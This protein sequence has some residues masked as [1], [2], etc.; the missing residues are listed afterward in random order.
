[1][2]ICIK[3]GFNQATVSF[4]DVKEKAKWT[5]LLDDDKR[6][7]EAEH[8]AYGCITMCLPED[9]LHTFE[10]ESY[11]TS[12]EHWDALA[13]RYKG[14]DVVKKGKQELL[15][16][17]H[18]VFKAM[19]NET[20]DELVNRDYHLMTEMRNHTVTLTNAEKNEKFLYALPSQWDFY[21]VLIKR[22]PT[23]AQMTL[24]TMIAHLRGF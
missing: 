15:K 5:A 14:D 20:L 1:M 16:A 23:Y 19:K 24:D 9:I 17:Q 12:K 10:Q 2:L 13:N 4:A 3:D 22:D 21:S 11:S 18:L 8:K 6:M 7:F